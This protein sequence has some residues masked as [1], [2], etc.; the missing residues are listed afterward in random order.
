MKLMFDGHLMFDLIYET[1]DTTH[2]TTGK[3]HTDSLSTLGRL[4]VEPSYASL[5]V[6]AEVAWACRKEHDSTA[7]RWLIFLSLANL[8][9]KS[10]IE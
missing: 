6:V 1:N 9:S 2:A 10:R 3:Q 5:E 4:V 8:T 7:L